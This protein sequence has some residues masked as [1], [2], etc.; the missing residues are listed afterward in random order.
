MENVLRLSGLLGEEDDEVDLAT[1]EK[2]LI[3]KTQKQ[4]RPSHATANSNATSPSLATTGQDGNPSTPQSAFT[5]PEPSHADERRNSLA[6]YQDERNGGNNSGS[7]NNNNSN[8]HDNGRENNQKDESE[9]EALSDMMCSLVTNQSGETRY[10][11][12]SICDAPK[13]H[14][15]PSAR[16]ARSRMLC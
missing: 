3:E 16:C 9:V 13:P 6:H 10:I 7:G 12:E 1:L 15:R 14:H 2:R 4:R 8:G 11:G 5:T